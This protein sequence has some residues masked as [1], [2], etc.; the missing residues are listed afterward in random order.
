MPLP[1]PESLTEG[2]RILQLFFWNYGPLSIV[3]EI[4]A[5][6]AESLSVPISTSTLG[7][8]LVPISAY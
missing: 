1:G 4:M 6:T 2:D 8:L 5:P 7:H 3:L